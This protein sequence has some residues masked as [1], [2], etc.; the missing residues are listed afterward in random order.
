MATRETPQFIG[1]P[2]LGDFLGWRL[3][4]AEAL[5]LCPAGG[6]VMRMSDG[7]HVYG[8]P[9]APRKRSRKAPAPS[10]AARKPPRAPRRRS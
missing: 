2:P 8:L 4:M 9:E 1:Q 10:Q 3:N 6:T 7:W 5:K